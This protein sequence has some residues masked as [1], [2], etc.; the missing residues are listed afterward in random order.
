V[1]RN[2]ESS[3]RF[4][5]ARPSAS[6]V[7]A[8]GA[9]PAGAS[10]ACQA[11]R[12]SIWTAARGRR[13]PAVP[14]ASAGPARAAVAR[15]AA[16]EHEPV[17]REAWRAGAGATAARRAGSGQ[18]RERHAALP[19][20]THAHAQH[21]AARAGGARLP[22]PEARRSAGC[23][24]ARLRPQADG[25]RRRVT[26]TAP[27]SAAGDDVCIVAASSWPPSR[28]RL[29]ARS[30]PAPGGVGKRTRALPLRLRAG[31]AGRSTSPPA[32]AA[33]AGGGAAGQ[34][35]ACCWRAASAAA[36]CGCC[37][38]AAASAV[39]PRHR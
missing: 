4:S 36:S 20:Q 12:T 16:G 15:P 37:A 2:H 21:R 22:R 24:A 3:Q 28:S 30:W 29:R 23:R 11:R 7:R 31:R 27:F 39:R 26:T 17:A 14:G 9:G 6:A 35:A 5:M 25:H 34:P 19:Y 1:P 13:W 38:C 8:L 18:I 32:R 33:G 10:S